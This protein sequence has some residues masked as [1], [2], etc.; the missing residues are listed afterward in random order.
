MKTIKSLCLLL[1]MVTALPPLVSG[2]PARTD[3]NPALLY[4]QAFQVAPDLSPPDRDYLFDREWRGQ[5]PPDRFGAL[6]SRYDNEFKLIRQAAQSKVPCDWGI[7]MSPGPATLL[8]HLARCKS[9]AQAVRLR[10]LWAL[11]NGRPDDAR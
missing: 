5:K 8:P 7:D 11:Q 1:L 6:V 10:L 3:I 2:A 9:V 4:F